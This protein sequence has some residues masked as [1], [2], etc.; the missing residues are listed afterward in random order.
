MGSTD[1]PPNICHYTNTT[2]SDYWLPLLSNASI[3]QQ[4]V[5][6]REIFSRYRKAA[7]NFLGAANRTADQ[8]FFLYLA[9]SHMHQLCAADNATTPPKQWAST[10]FAERSGGCEAVAAVE[11]TDALTG[12]V[13]AALEN[14]GLAENTLVFWTVSRAGQ[15][16]PCWA[17]ARGRAI[18]SVTEPLLDS[19]RPTTAHGRM[20]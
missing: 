20:S 4:P 17:R 3:V 14:S 9:F 8:P 13:L 7:E 10:E 19:H 11:E 16:R 5:D 15:P 12:A 6:T 18:M 1:F 2:G